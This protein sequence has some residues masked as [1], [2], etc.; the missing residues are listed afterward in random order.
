MK[1]I[2]PIAKIA[3]EKNTPLEL[4]SQVRKSIHPVVGPVDGASIQT[5]TT[6]R[7]R[8][9]CHYGIIVELQISRKNLSFLLNLEIGARI[10]KRPERPRANQK[11]AQ[12]PT[13]VWQNVVMRLFQQRLLGQL[14]TNSYSI[15]SF[16]RNICP[17]I[18]HTCVLPGMLQPLVVDEASSI[19]LNVGK[20]SSIRSDR[21]YSQIIPC[22]GA[23]RNHEF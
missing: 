17:T 10:E 18:T 5:T 15:A 8:L 4:S 13:Y 9:W 19:L 21:K 22:C 11:T 20:S 2:Y 14:K 7:S 16:T 3:G 23:Y 12:R 6:K 1:D